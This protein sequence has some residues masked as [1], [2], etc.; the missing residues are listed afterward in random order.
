[1][2]HDQDMLSHLIHTGR[3]IQS[4][5]AE[6]L[7][8]SRRYLFLE[9][10][11]LTGNLTKLR[12]LAYRR[13]KNVDYL[14]E[15]QVAFWHMQSDW[16]AYLAKHMVR[17]CLGPLAGSGRMTFRERNREHF[18]NQGIRRLTRG[19]WLH[20]RAIYERYFEDGDFREVLNDRHWWQEG[21]FTSP[22]ME[23]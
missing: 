11:L 21:V 23:D 10:P 8:A 5:P 22:T 7:A 3:I 13:E 2:A 18:V 12:P 16:C 20:R 4:D 19:R 15:K 17:E 9:N 1:M 14:N 6:F